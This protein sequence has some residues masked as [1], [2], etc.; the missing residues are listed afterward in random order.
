MVDGVPRIFLPMTMREPCWIV[1]SI[2][3]PPAP[4]TA[5]RTALASG[6]KIRAPLWKGDAS[7]IL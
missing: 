4:A 1:T 5:T 7:T 3:S 2:A 6:S